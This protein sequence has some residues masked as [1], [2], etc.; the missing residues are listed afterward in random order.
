MTRFIGWVLC[1]LIVCCLVWLV[2]TQPAQAETPVPSPSASVTPTPTP[3]V[4]PSAPASVVRAALKTRRAAVRVWTKWNKARWC[5]GMTHRPFASPKPARSASEAVWAAA[6]AHWRGMRLDYRHRFGILWERMVHPHGNAWERWR[7]L[8]R[9]IWP[10]HLVGTV[11]EV[12]H[13]ESSGNPR[14]LCGGYVLPPGAGDGEPD[15]RAGGL[16]QNKPAP[17]H[18]A[19]PYYNLWYAFHVKFLHGGWAHWAGC[20]AFR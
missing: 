1:L 7:P 9:W 13:Y 3:V 12:M 6:R 2:S 11:I 4:V 19:D 8:V 20:A 10:A 14:V 17:R 15:S 16:M 5:L 18:W